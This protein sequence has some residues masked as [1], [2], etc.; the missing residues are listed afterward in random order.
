MAKSKHSSKK[1]NLKQIQDIN[2]R[3]HLY[4]TSVINDEGYIYYS[5][6]LS[7]LIKE[8]ITTGNPPKL[9]YD[10][11]KYSTFIGLIFGCKYTLAYAGEALD[12]IN[13]KAYPYYLYACME[14]VRA[15]IGQLP[16]Q[17]NQELFKIV[18]IE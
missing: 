16:Y 15:D 1:P 3:L 10:F 6:V 7:D 13:T 17:L 12:E 8:Y 18:G 9:L 5:I 2:N 4:S 14:Y 11:I